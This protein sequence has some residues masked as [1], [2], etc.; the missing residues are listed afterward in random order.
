M[1]PALLACHIP[2]LP[3]PFCNAAGRDP[4][5]LPTSPQIEIRQRRQPWCIHVLLTGMQ[6]VVAAWLCTELSSQGTASARLDRNDVV[7][8]CPT[9]NAQTT[10]ATV[11]SDVQ[12]VG[13]CVKLRLTVLGLCCSEREW[14]CASIPT[15]TPQHL[16][17]PSAESSREPAVAGNLLPPLRSALMQ[18]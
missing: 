3:L 10:G 14:H 18:P 2:V 11:N 7:H 16:I 8:A 15:A 9:A 17:D 5:F 12:Q 13:M 4:R 6:Y 1:L